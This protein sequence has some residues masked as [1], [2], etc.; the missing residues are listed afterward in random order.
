MTGLHRARDFGTASGAGQN[1]LCGV[2]FEY[3]SGMRFW[4]SSP[5]SVMRRAPPAMDLRELAGGRP[6]IGAAEPASAAAGAARL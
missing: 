5:G 6:G 1:S 2:T 4:C 3:C